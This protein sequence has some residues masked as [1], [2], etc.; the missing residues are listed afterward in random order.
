ME[1]GGVE[2]GGDGMGLY[3]MG[4]C[5]YGSP[6]RRWFQRDLMNI[7][8]RCRALSPAVSTG[9]RRDVQRK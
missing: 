6:L 4:M 2:L 8:Y 3:L 9:A 5:D 7:P 1:L